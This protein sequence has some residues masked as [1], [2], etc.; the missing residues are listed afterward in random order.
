MGVG[1][2]PVSA[3]A[4]YMVALSC[5]DCGA[6]GPWV[7]GVAVPNAV[8][9]ALKQGW[10]ANGG[11]DL[12][13]DCVA[14]KWRRLVDEARIPRCG[15]DAVGY[16]LSQLAFLMNDGLARVEFLARVVKWCEAGAGASVDPGR[17]VWPG[18]LTGAPTLADVARPLTY[19]EGPDF[20][21]AG[22][23]AAALL[24]SVVSDA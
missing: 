2:G 20:A 16:P 21:R 1:G 23:R 11:R 22:D 13:P 17:A 12:C 24:R 9:A 7:S 3:V 15:V 8:G 18:S 10:T 4:K 5:D 19:P 14:P 6:E